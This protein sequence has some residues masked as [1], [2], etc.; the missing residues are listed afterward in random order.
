MGP[1]DARAGISPSRA[2]GPGRLAGLCSGR[3]SHA[4]PT[5]NRARAM[6]PAHLSTKTTAVIGAGPYGLSVAAHLRARAVPTLVFGE[7]MESW[8]MMPARMNLKSVW[9]A[10]S[11]AD[12]E[13]ALSLDAFCRA[14][15]SVVSEPIPLDFLIRSGSWFQHISGADIHR[16]SGG[17]LPPQGKGFHPALS[18]RRALTA[19]GGGVGSR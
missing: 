8:H 7:P 12:P 3:S 10:S 1:A 2:G 15:G 18:N 19:T 5:V 4:A 13:G 14:T 6:T 9:S 17:C 16:V 11:L